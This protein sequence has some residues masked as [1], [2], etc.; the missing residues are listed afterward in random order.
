MP[1]DPVRVETTRA[2]LVKVDTDLRSASADLSAT[3]AIAE[4]VLFHSQ[5]AAEKALKAFL[6]WHDRL[7][8]KTHD[9]AELSAVCVEIDPGLT[10][11]L[12][13]AKEL[14]KYAWMFRYPG[15]PYQPDAEEAR[16]MLALS[17]EIV[18]AILARLPPEVRP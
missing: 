2:W 12:A 5:Q 3:P 6:N 15:A 13:R 14:T 8:G 1:H 11:L 10:P 9:L 17:R 4:D 16:R 7:F 18:E